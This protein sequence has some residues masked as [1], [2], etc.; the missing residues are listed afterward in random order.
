MVQ[1]LIARL[2]RGPEKQFQVHHIVNDHWKCSVVL[3]VR[4]AVVSGSPTLSAPAT[5]CEPGYGVA[6]VGCIAALGG[7][8]PNMRVEPSSERVSRCDDYICVSAASDT[9][10]STILLVIV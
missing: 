3:W 9:I 1:C 6:V 5:I 8:V 2:L 7:G 10:Q 4:S